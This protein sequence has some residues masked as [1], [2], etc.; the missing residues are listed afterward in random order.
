MRKAVIL[1]MSLLGKGDHLR[2]GTMRKAIMISVGLIVLALVPSEA[3]ALIK[4]TEGQVRNV[5]GRSLETGPGG[6]TCNKSCGLNGEHSCS[7]TCTKKF[8]CTG[9]CDTCRGPSRQNKS[10]AVIRAELALPS[11]KRSNSS[12]PPY[13]S[14]CYASCPP[15]NWLCNIHCQSR[16][17]CPPLS[18]GRTSPR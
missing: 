16:G 11:M 15:G 7:F 3:S 5:C 17:P 14:W 13:C 1:I 9:F 6:I 12:L 4:L 2:R 10:N 8:G 18:L